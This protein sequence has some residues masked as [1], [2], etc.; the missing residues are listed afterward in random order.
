M[1]WSDSTNRKGQIRG[2]LSAYRRK[3]KQL[4]KIPRISSWCSI[5]IKVMDFFLDHALCVFPLFWHIWTTFILPSH[6]SS[7][8]PSNEWWGLW[9]VQTGFLSPTTAKWV[10]LRFDGPLD[11]LLTMSNFEIVT[12][13]S[14]FERLFTQHVFYKKQNFLCVLDVVYRQYRHCLCESTKTQ[15]C[16]NTEVMR[17]CVFTL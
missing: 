14:G 9:L 15:F 12:S 10:T 4:W 6:T 3:K 7:M 17:M 2:L 8:M 11:I 16:E 5:F 13:V 1:W